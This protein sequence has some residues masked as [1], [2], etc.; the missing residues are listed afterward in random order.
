ML[1]DRHIFGWRFVVLNNRQSILLRLLQERIAIDIV[2]EHNPEYG[3]QFREAPSPCDTF[4]HDH[5]QQIGCEHHL[6]LCFDGIGTL[7]IERSQREVLLELFEQQLN[8]SSLPVNCH[9]I[10]NSH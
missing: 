2:H 6:N 5:K 1:K 10:L 4:L 9:D 3:Y 7:F 8:F